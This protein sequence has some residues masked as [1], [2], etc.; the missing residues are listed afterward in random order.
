MENAKRNSAIN[1]QY[2]GSPLNLNEQHGLGL[3]CDINVIVAKHSGPTGLFFHLQCVIL[4]ALL[5]CR[6]KYETKITIVIKSDDNDDDDGDDV[7]VIFCLEFLLA[8]VPLPNTMQWPRSSASLSQTKGSEKLLESEA[9]THLS[10]NIILLNQTPLLPP[11]VSSAL[12]N[13]VSPL[14]CFLMQNQQKPNS[15]VLLRNIAN[16]EVGEKITHDEGHT[17]DSSPEYKTTGNRKDPSLDSNHLSEGRKII[18]LNKTTEIEVLSVGCKVYANTGEYSIDILMPV[19][20]N[21]LEGEAR[22]ENEISKTTVVFLLAEFCTQHEMH[23]TE[24]WFIAKILLETQ[25]SI[26]HIHVDL[27]RSDNM[28]TFLIGQVLCLE[29]RM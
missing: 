23:H 1:I 29:W 24:D 9:Q 12:P 21:P 15:T 11:E 27:Y 25:S 16:D 18:N 6:A 26:I 22:L 5:R 20:D 10:P 7:H 3:I 13:P 8:K 19:K 2:P 28:H 17:I 4:S 14:V